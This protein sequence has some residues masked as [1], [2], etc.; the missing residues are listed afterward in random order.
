M[1]EPVY[2]VRA[3]LADPA[4]GV[5]EFAPAKCLWYGGHALLFIGALV[6][7]GPDA[8]SPAA[9]LTAVALLH[10][11]LLFGHS[12]GFHRLL[13][14]RTYTARPLL[15]AGLFWAGALVGMGGP[16]D[17][18]RLHDTRDWAQRQARA[19]PYFSHDLPFLRDVWWQMTSRFR[20]EHA[21]DV[22]LLPDEASDPLIRHFDRWWRVHAMLPAL[23]LYLLFGWAGVA[24]GLSARILVSALG[25]WSVVHLCHAPHR[26][27][28]G[29]GE[30]DVPSAGVQA[31]DLT[32]GTLA[33]FAA[34]LTHGECWH[35]HH[36]AF[37]ES[38][39]IG[40]AHQPDPGHAVLRWMERRGWVSD[41]R[42]RRGE[43]E[44]GDLARRVSVDR[45]P[46]LSATGR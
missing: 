32:S 23:P 22:N 21:P 41:L 18:A 15:R 44:R 43:A 37:P 4:K 33:Y 10:L 2:R 3:G 35:N 25:H 38:A 46:T 45:R 11:T 19:H 20:F 28:A 31:S 30:L 6:L 27:M 17:V 1:M 16:G 40:F 7:A 29:H 9:L 39:R 8:L 26:A 14:H 42:G 36:H 12:L 13:I 34:L 5:V 24:W